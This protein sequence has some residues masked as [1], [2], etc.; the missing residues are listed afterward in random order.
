MGQWS[1][2]L[3]EVEQDKVKQEKKDE[4][5]NTITL[6]TGLT[7][8]IE[9]LEDQFTAILKQFDEKGRRMASTVDFVTSSIESLTRQFRL[10]LQQQQN[11]LARL[12]TKFESQ[13]E[14]WKRKL[15]QQEKT[16][17]QLVAKFESQQK[18]KED[19]WKRKFEQQD[20]TMAQMFA[21]FESQQK[22]KEDEWEKRLREQQNEQAQLF[23]KFESQQQLKEEEWKRKLDQQ[24]SIM[25][26][27]LEKF[28]LPTT[29][30][31]FAQL[32]SLL[33]RNE[34]EWKEYVERQL[35]AKFQLL[36]N[37]QRTKEEEWKKRVEQQEKTMVEL[38]AKFES[39][40][41]LTEEERRR[42]LDQQQNEQAQLIAKFESQQQL[43]EEEWKRRVDQQE[44]AITQQLFAKF[45]AQWQQN[46]ERHQNELA[47]LQAKIESL[48]SEQ[49][50]KNDA[51]KQ[52]EN[53]KANSFVNC[54]T[55]RF[56]PQQQEQVTKEDEEQKNESSEINGETTNYESHEDQNEQ[57]RDEDELKEDEHEGDEP[58]EDIQ[59]ESAISEYTTQVEPPPQQHRADQM[60]N[61]ES[62]E[63]NTI[64]QSQQ[65][66]NEN[67]DD[68]EDNQNRNM[69]VT[70]NASEPQQQSVRICVRINDSESTGEPELENENSVS[71]SSSSQ[72]QE[73]TQSN[74]VTCYEKAIV[75]DFGSS[76]IKAGFA[77]EQEYPNVVFPSLVG[78]R[79]TYGM[80]TIYGSNTKDIFFGEEAQS[81]GLLTLSSP[82]KRGIVTNFDDWEKL[83][84]HTLYNELRVDPEEHPVLLTEPP[85]NLRSDKEKMTQIMFE[86][87]SVP[88]MYM[89]AKAVLSLY[90]S[91]RTTGIVLD[92]GD[93]SSHSVPIY[94]G[95]AIRHAISKIDL[96]GCDLT[97]Y[98]GRIITESGRCFPP[99]NGKIVDN[100]KEKLCYVAL[101]FE[102]EMKR[103]TES[104]ALERS[105]ELPDGNVI[106]VGNQRFRCPEVL[107]QPSLHG[108]EA[109]GVHE[110]VFNSIS[111]SAID[112]RK[113]LY[114]NIVLS[115][116]TTMFEGFNERL[117]KELTNLA[118][119]SMKIKIV[120]PQSRKY[121]VWIGGSILASLP[122]FE[123]MW[124]SKEEY[125]DSGPGIIHRKCF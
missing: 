21:K 108:M 92:C 18:L 46:A 76:T 57:N 117:T 35:Q 42:K 100:I 10:D 45:D 13:G 110:I 60:E 53:N 89:S 68:I 7:R 64:T 1:S 11:D 36:Q 39:Q 102:E 17:V 94:E 12:Q 43:K 63:T 98:L 16:M 23:A 38:I 49:T 95:Y 58:E 8:R 72:H 88:A 22:L 90:A 106:T 27:F 83:M 71:G 85:F 24:E 105:Y 77:G 9:S 82:M 124:I 111:S 29:N 3:I 55:G 37:E 47:L 93:G 81:R 96:A 32:E 122:T 73:A 113:D 52:N 50:T 107:F 14:E 99:S 20:N 26:Q 44:S 112:I 104:S 48:Q 101:D 4:S 86:T 62:E 31:L 28:E 74:Y 25:A 118:P 125:E 15:D 66:F 65:I 70:S 97:E 75:I 121:S 61:K 109:A 2:Q 19:E 91:G 41:R 80:V 114:A 119:A 6:L 103:A 87:F 69:V 123:Q 30:Q 34:N 67:D 33:K 78:R 120:A 54:S 56:E 40:Q 84:H 5:K 115:G 79:K 116:G 59:N 51:I